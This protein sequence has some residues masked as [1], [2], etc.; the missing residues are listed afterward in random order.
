MVLAE[1]LLLSAV[2]GVLGILMAAA[3]ARVLVHLISTGPRALP[4][5]FDPDAR[6]LGF[7]LAVS[8]FTGILFGIAP[9]LRG[10][11]RMSCSC[12]RMS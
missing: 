11:P 3:G 4:I 5:G 12:T 1:S 10:T 7:T 9:A 2:G 6:V 8:L